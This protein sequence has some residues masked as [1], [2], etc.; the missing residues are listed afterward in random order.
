MG[1]NKQLLLVSCLVLGWTTSSVNASE[2]KPADEK[3][4]AKIH[5]V[6]DLVYGRVQGA[7]LLADVAYPASDKPLPVLLSVH[8]GRWRAGHR[9][10]ASSINVKQWAG[11]GFF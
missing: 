1:F 8:G 3:S 9:R 5:F 2:P 6:E 11:F 4:S 7:G 10:D